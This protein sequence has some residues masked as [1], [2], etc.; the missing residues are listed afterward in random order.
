M[1]GE[2]LQAVKEQPE[3]RGKVIDALF[4]VIE[5]DIDFGGIE[6]GY[7]AGEPIVKHAEKDDRKRLTE[8]IED[9]IIPVKSNSSRWS[10]NAF[11]RMLQDLYTTDGRGEEFLEKEKDLGLHEILAYLLLDLDRTAEAVEVATEHLTSAYKTIQ[12]ADRLLELNE[13]D[14]A[15]LLVERRGDRNHDD[16]LHVWLS[17]FEEKHGDP[18]TAFQIERKRFQNGGTV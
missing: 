10:R 13:I 5:W 2:C 11:G 15:H 12:F 6:M 9:R 1:L 4:S 14:K 8:R 16:R 18:E 17:E 3:S 7:G